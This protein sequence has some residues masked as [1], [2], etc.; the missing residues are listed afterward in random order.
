VGQTDRQ[1]DGRIVASLNV[2]V[3]GGDIIAFCYIA[4]RDNLDCI[5]HRSPYQLAICACMY[6][7]SSMETCVLLRPHKEAEYCV[8]V[9]VRVRVRVCAVLNSYT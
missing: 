6:A 5:L 1:T 3:Y 2:P 4:Y 7:Y 9:C 8:C